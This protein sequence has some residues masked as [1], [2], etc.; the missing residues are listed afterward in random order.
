MTHGSLSPIYLK[1]QRPVWKKFVAPIE[2]FLLLKSQR[3]VATCPT[4]KKW[5]EEYLNGKPHPEIVIEDLKRFF[6]LSGVTSEESFEDKTPR[7]KIHLLYLGRRHPLKGLQFLQEAV[8]TLELPVEL[9]I[10]SDVFGA[11]KRNVW[12]WCDV[13]VNP[14]LSEN[15]SFVVA[16]ALERG[17]SVIITDGAPAWE[18]QE[19]LSSSGKTDVSIGFRGKL[20]Y[21]RGYCQ[22]S[23]DIKVNLLKDAL[24]LYKKRLEERKNETPG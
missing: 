24:R 16:E 10:V 7:E 14:T 18:T 20:F 3:I 4:E 13:L 1:R 17:K 12:D 23:K 6:D 15:F 9:R 2:R 21:L 11:E 22:A 8:D 19:A 5:I